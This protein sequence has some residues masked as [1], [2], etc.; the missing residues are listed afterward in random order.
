MILCHFSKLVS[1]AA[2]SL[3]IIS[4]CLLNLDVKFMVLKFS[5][6]I[7]YFFYSCSLSLILSLQHPHTFPS[8]TSHVSL[9]SSGCP[10]IRGM[11][12]CASQLLLQQFPMGVS[13]DYHIVQ[14]THDYPLN[15]GQI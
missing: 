2:E 7:I 13:G 14:V 4:T 12:S 8:Q 11:G 15:G 6:F 5:R 3:H 9:W 1:A 10:D